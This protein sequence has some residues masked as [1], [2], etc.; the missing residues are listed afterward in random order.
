MIADPAAKAGLAR[1]TVFAAVMIVCNGIVGLSLLVGGVRHHEQGFQIQGAS[2]ALAVL[3][4]L[5]VAPLG[6]L[7]PELFPTARRGGAR[8]ALNVLAV[9]GSVS[10]LVLAGAGVDAFGYGPTFVLLALGP[11]IAA[12]LAFAVPE[13][14]GR[15]LED[16]NPEE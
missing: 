12:A 8:G 6:V 5:T 4:A 10:G 7:A 3:G 1:D 2:A 13:T 9:T 16:I 14:G 11:L 15:E